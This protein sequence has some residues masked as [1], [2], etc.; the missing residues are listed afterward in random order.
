LFALYI[1]NISWSL[2]GM[3]DVITNANFV[4]LDRFRSIP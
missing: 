1:F 3:K 4:Y 2:I